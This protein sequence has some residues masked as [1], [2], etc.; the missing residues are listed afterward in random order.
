MKQMTLLQHFSE[1]RR[2]IL[3]VALIFV[4]AFVCGWYVAPELQ[5]FLTMPLLSV[6]GDGALI[7]T[8]LTDGLMIQF[9]LAMLFALV[10]IKS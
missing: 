2:R 8:G 7:Y 3:W 9:S 6:W 10:V 4:C 5:E 1:L